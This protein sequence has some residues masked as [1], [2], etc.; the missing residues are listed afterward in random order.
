M[1]LTPLI[2]K[3]NIDKDKLNKLSTVTSQTP[4]P[5]N[6]HISNKRIKASKILGNMC[7]NKYMRR[8]SDWIKY[9]VNTLIFK[10]LEQ[11]SI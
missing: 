1:N 9:K 7:K 11:N 6:T 8:S 5:K 3:N 10:D 2:V 4:K